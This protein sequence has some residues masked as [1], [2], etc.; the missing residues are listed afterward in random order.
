M[1]VG[2]LRDFCISAGMGCV[3]VLAQLP[4]G[5]G[6]NALGELGTTVGWGANIGMALIVATGVG[7]FTGEWKGASKRALTPLILGILI[8]LAAVAA[9]GYANFLENAARVAFSKGG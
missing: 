3:H 5:V 8:L 1:S 4:Y 7:F 6:E 9:L 2:S